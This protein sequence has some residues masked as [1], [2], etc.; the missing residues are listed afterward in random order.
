MPDSAL[1]VADLPAGVALVPRAVEFL[2]CHSELHDEVARQVLRLGLAPFLAPQADQGGLIAAHNDA[3][4]GAADEA[5]AL[6]R[7]S[8]N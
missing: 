2:G 6:S 7:G 5:A 1:D 8:G 4:V 3:G